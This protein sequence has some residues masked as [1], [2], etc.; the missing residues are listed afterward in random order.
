MYRS[1]IIICQVCAEV[2]NSD[3]PETAFQTR[4]PG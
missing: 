2:R 3:A 4:R 1:A